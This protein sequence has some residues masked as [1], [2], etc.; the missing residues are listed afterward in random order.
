ML[1]K[2]TH[3]GRYKKGGFQLTMDD[4]YIYEELELYGYSEEE[5]SEDFEIWD[6]FDDQKEEFEKQLQSDFPFM[7]QNHDEE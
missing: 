6:G 7:L 2:R 4:N 5:I 1:C 3:S